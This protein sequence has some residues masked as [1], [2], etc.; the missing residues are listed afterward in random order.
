MV[1]HRK[2]LGR[3]LVLSLLLITSSALWGRHI[4]GGV[5]TYECLGDDRYTFTLKVYRDCNCVQCATIDEI[6]EI[7]IYQCDEE[8]QCPDQGQQDPWQSLSVRLEGIREVEEPDYPCLIPPEVCGQEG[9][10]HFTVELPRS[11]LSYYVA[12]QRCCRNVTIDNMINPEDAGA[13][14]AIE[15]TPYAQ[16]TCNSSPSFDAYPPIIIC[17]NAPLNY[18]HSATDPDGDLLVYEFCAP[19]L[20]GG[21][22]LDPLFYNTCDGAHPIPAC[23]PPYQAV[24]FQAPTYTATRPMAGD[25]VVRINS[26]TGLI[27]GTPRLQGQFV[28]GVCVSE[29]REGRLLSKVYRDFQFNVASCDPTVVADVKEDFKLSEQEFVINSCGNATVTFNN[30]SFQRTYIDNI[31]WTFDLGDGTQMTASDWSPTMSFPGVG[32][33]R[34]QLILNENTHCGD[35]ADIFVNVY[36]E[37]EADFTYAYDTCRAAP[38]VFTDLSTTGACCLTDWRWSFG[39]GNTSVV[40]DPAHR[41]QLPGNL[42][43]TLTVRDTNACEASSTQ[44]IGYFPAPAL[45]VVSPS[46][47]VDCVPADI[48]FDNLSFPIDSTYDIIWDFGDGGRGTE[49]SPW[50]TY[51]T[52]GLFTVR[53]DITSPI[54]CQVDTTFTNLIETL[55]SPIGGFSYLPEQLSNI[56]PEVQFTDASEGASSWRWFFGSEQVGS[57]LPSPRYIFPDTGLYLIEQVV[58]HPSGCTDTVRALLDVIPEVRYYLPNAFTPNGDGANDDFKGKGFME[59]ISDFE[60]TIWNRWGEPLFQ[61]TDPHAA[62]NGQKHN[63]GQAA[64]PGVY[65]VTVSYRDPRGNVVELQG[66]ATLIR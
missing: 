23:R 62:W 48:F 25:P 17:E 28:V 37:I 27:T 3:C 44:T 64:P 22:L 55:P 63:S 41:Y 56:Q 47:A 42:P 33:Y 61:T 49:I 53:I 51:E 43:V 18:D 1:Q 38:V 58:T 34:G 36:P 46:A 65:L 7:S 59:G 32:Q 4:I 13:T 16:Q 45:I 15:V 5:M 6:A 52:P 29:Y 66:Y 39:D 2:Y 20:G 57:T 19:L 10:Y 12:Y 21:P 54:G 9:V 24:S 35:T 50:H 26:Q 14:F 31:R 30:E 8:G 11:D 40:Q 60:L